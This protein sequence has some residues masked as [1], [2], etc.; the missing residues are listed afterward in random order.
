MGEMGRETGL[1]LRWRVESKNKESLVL[2]KYV[3]YTKETT[4]SSFSKLF[5]LSTGGMFLT[6]FGK[7]D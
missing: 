6:S 5:L 2:A 4:L 3:Q 7:V 1:C